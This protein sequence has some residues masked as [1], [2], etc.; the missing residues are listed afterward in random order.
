MVLKS[1]TAH[2]KMMFAVTQSVT[3]VIESWCLAHGQLPILFFLITL[4][5][6]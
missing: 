2:L 1:K 4:L 5:L 6:G 3:V